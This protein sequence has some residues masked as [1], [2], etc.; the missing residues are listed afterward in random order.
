MM[1]QKITAP[2][3]QPREVFVHVATTPRHLSCLPPTGHVHVHQLGVQL[4]H[5]AF[6]HQRNRTMKE[7]SSF[8]WNVILSILHQQAVP[9][10]P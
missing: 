6:V 4:Q 5:K 1:Q 9:P 10:L 7:T 3:E 8:T 2:P